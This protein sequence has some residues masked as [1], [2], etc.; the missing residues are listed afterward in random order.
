[1]IKNHLEFFIRKGMKRQKGYFKIKRANV[2]LYA[3]D[4][5]RKNGMYR[6]FEMKI[7]GGTRYFPYW[8]NVTNPSYAP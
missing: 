8:V 2:I 6:E 1:M 4:I 5:D 7:D 3:N